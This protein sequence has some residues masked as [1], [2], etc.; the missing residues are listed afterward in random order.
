M[1]LS[2]ETGRTTGDFSL[3]VYR[4]TRSDTAV[5]Q[6]TSSWNFPD[7]VEREVPDQPEILSDL[8]DHLPET[9]LRG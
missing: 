5:N 9:Q 4:E 3:Q 1:L 6:R 7:G 8:G 2:K